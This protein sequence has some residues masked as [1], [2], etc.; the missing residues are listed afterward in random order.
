M[1]EQELELGSG[2]KYE[3]VPARRNDTDKKTGRPKYFL[4][5]ACEDS[6]DIIT[7]PNRSRRDVF[8]NLGAMHS[9]MD[10]EDLNITDRKKRSEFTDGLIKAGGKLLNG[11]PGGFFV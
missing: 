9:I 4:V 1:E 11:S 7:N 8:A 10:L 2:E 6:C 5:E 3:F